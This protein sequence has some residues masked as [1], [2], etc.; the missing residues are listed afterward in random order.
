[1]YLYLPTMSDIRAT[2]PKTWNDWK[3][4]L[5]AEL[6]KKTAAQINKGI[7]QQADKESNIFE[8]QTASLRRLELLGIDSHQANELWQTSDSEYF[9]G[10]T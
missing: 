6:Y 7:D 10:H 4:K 5:L 3:D 9:Q 8:I 2:N 1:V